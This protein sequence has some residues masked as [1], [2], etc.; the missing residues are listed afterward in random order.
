[1]GSFDVERDLATF[2]RKESG[3]FYIAWGADQDILTGKLRTQLG[4]HSVNFIKRGND[5]TNSGLPIGRWDRYNWVK[6]I[7]QIHDCHL[8]PEG[9]TDGGTDRLIDM[10]KTIY[11]ETNWDWIKDYQTK[12]KQSYL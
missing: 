7:G 9:Y 1:M 5:P 11:P 2:A 6:P 12:F 8:S 3:D 4:Y 10:C